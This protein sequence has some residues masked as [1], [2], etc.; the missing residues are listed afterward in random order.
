VRIEREDA[1]WKSA[2]ATLSSEGSFVLQVQLA[3][4]RQSRFRLIAL[5]AGGA[6]IALGTDGFAIVHG[7]SVADPPLSRAVGVAC[8]DDSTQ[9]Y[10]ARGTP[11]PARRTF[12]LETVAAIG[13]RTGE[14]ALAIPVVQGESRRAH[15]NRLIGMLRLQGVKRDLPA[16]SRVELTLELDRSG[17]LHARAD[18]PAAGQTF[19][20]VVH[21]LVPSASL[22]TIAQELEATGQRATE[23][24]RRT[25]QAGLPAA[26]TALAEVPGL[27]AEAERAHADAARGDGDAD[28]AQK[29]HRRLL[30]AGAALDEAE[31]ILAW[32]ELEGEARR[33]TLYY[34]PLV[35]R[36]GTAAEQE[37]FD[38]ALHAT[39]AAQ[40]TR[41]AAE[42]ER[43]LEAMRSL[44]RASYCRDPRSLANEL[45]WA[46][47]HVT[48]A[49][50]VAA[51]QQLVER[52]RAAE[53]EGNRA[54]L[55]ALVA[56]LWEL[57]PGSPEL[58]E[59]SFGSGVR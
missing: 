1:G 30:E 34:T 36:W 25:F 16:G 13:A 35:A 50:D 3:R 57:Y 2:E 58:R 59:K 45:E 7:V 15:R 40:K 52:A 48:Q 49:M 56:R 32:P 10:F 27:L 4:H 55:H 6:A 29:A 19:A 47:A 20:E 23:L 31:A 42:L 54:A 17:Q 14:D 11:L 44:G 51:A 46:T 43:Q 41:D 53:A 38:Q 9:V 28:A 8:A 18:V 39:L 26:A 22:Q 12:V 5:D 21:V 37:L 24:Q 33:W